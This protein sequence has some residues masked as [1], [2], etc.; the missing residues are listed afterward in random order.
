M[1]AN[2]NALYYQV[3]GH[4]IP[5]P[6]NAAFPPADEGHGYDMGQHLPPALQMQHAGPDL[7]GK[8][9]APTKDDSHDNFVKL[10][11]AVNSDA[12]QAGAA[13]A[14]AMAAEDARGNKRKRALS[15]AS[16]PASAASPPADAM[17]QAA[18][19]RF[20]SETA[21][22]TDSCLQAT[23]GSHRAE[24]FSP[25]YSRT[26]SSETLLQG[27]RAAGVH[28]AAA[29]FRRPN[30]EPA[31]KY[32]RPPMSKLFMSLQLTPENFLQLQ[33]RAKLY[34]LDPAH[35]ERQTCVGNRGK[36]DTDMV[37][38]KLFNC[39]RD[40][41]DCGIGE[42]FFGKDVEKPLETEAMEAARALGEDQ[43]APGEERLVWPRDGNKII[44]LVTPL[45]RRMVTNERQRKYALKTRKGGSRKKE[46]S[47]DASP[48]EA[49]PQQQPDLNATSPLVASTVTYPNRHPITTSAHLPQ[50]PP[51]TTIQHIHPQSRAH[52]SDHG[53]I[54]SSSSSSWRESLSPKTYPLPT[55]SD[56]D[57]D[58]RK[59]DIFLSRNLLRLQPRER[60]KG[61]EPLVNFSWA[62]LQERITSLLQQ[63]VERYPD[64]RTSKASTSTE[65]TSTGS[66]DLRGL[67]VA[68]S[69][70]GQAD[71][72]RER[73]AKSETRSLKGVVHP[74]TKSQAGL[75]PEPFYNASPAAPSSTSSLDAHAALT[76]DI[77]Q[78]EVKTD[79]WVLPKYK[80]MALR[81]QGLSEVKNE[82]EWAEVMYEVPYAAW[83]NGRVTVVVE[84][85]E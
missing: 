43:P 10:M 44:S 9:L 30:K 80:V 77:F 14:A 50:L 35:P 51:T 6:A 33:S 66:E 56:R 22:F 34:M 45:L 53:C 61:P 65:T 72:T 7:S 26:P 20:R 41:L 76:S 24:P 27:A 73:V 59:I 19:K 11:K 36:G 81:G 8:K 3:G 42:Q 28:S 39:V 58:L 49:T 55:W 71:D 40:F 25:Q 48:T 5:Q 78:F 52:M 84:V 16:S 46:E 1:A 37:K 32:T 54:S 21:P 18:Y 67:A 85:E 13:A 68:A 38:L 47:A 29:L 23:Q 15:G 82:T 62:N 64:L 75:E 17:A 63:A 69:E 74:E 2:S 4:F 79:N 70:I 31:R 57:F 60:V 12:G 83:A